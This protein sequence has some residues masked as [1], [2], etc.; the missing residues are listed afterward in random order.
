MQESKHGN[1]M[2]LVPTYS[3]F[4]FRQEIEGFKDT[5]GV[6]EDNEAIKNMTY[7]QKKALLV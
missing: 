3:N 4:L 2:Y 7:M 1:K 5:Y 6:A